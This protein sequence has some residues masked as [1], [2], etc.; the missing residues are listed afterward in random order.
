M[1][2]ASPHLIAPVIGI[3]PFDWPVISLE[4]QGRSRS[5]EYP[6]GLGSPPQHD[7]RHRQPARARARLSRRRTRT[8]DLLG[9]LVVWNNA[10]GGSEVSCS[11][12][13]PKPR[14]GGP[15]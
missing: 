4:S 11:R 7:T 15:R 6:A 13:D 9:S 5:L 10:A 2:L 8:A 12:N 3:T 14:A 1:K